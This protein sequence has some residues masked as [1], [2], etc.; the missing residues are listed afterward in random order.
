MKGVLI[1]G[2]LR[3]GLRQWGDGEGGRQTWGIH[4]E[5]EHINNSEKSVG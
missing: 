4:N 1:F 3:G 5:L 2:G